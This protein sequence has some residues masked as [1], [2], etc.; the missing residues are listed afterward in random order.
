MILKALITRWMNAL[1][2]FTK[3]EKENRFSNYFNSLYDKWPSGKDWS[4]K[5]SNPSKVVNCWNISRFLK[6]L[7]S[8]FWPKIQKVK[9]TL[10]R[11]QWS[12]EDD[13]RDENLD[14]LRGD[15]WTIFAQIFVGKFLFYLYQTGK[16]WNVLF[17]TR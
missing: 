16:M 5:M 3:I 12:F 6:Q 14:L 11:R 15:L 7:P 17:K 1:L 13:L 8:S 4:G 9:C 10:G 2:P